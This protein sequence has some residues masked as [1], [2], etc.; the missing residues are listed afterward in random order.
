MASIFRE[1]AAEARRQRLY[2]DI[3]IYD[4]R[5]SSVFVWVVGLLA[6]TTVAVAMTATYPR[7]EQ[8]RGVVATSGPS[9]KILPLRSGTVERLYVKNGDWVERG[10]PLALVGVDTR[11]AS[12][13]GAARESLAALD[14]RYASVVK[15]LR[16]SDEVLRAERSR[17]NDALVANKS[18][19]AAL[20]Q[21]LQLQ[22]AII[23]AKSDEL[24][25]IEPVADQGYV[26]KFELDHRRQALLAERQRL[27]QYQQQRVQLEASR[28]SLT[29]QLHQ[30]PTEHER[31]SAELEAQLNSIAQEQSRTRV[32]IGY[33]LVAPIDGYV[34]AV[35]GTLGRNADPRIPLMVLVPKETHFRVELLA[36]SKAAGFLRTGQEVRIAY[37]AFPYKQFGTASGRIASISRTTYA[38]TELDL[39]L[40]VTEPVYRVGVSLDGKSSPSKAELLPLQAG[41][42]LTASVVL[43]RRSFIDWL[44]QPLN[45]VRNRA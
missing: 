12:R 42:T 32:E 2:G 24:A 43:E 45:A 19:Y 8:V 39:P 31:R 28:L 22:S 29:A 25:R 38:P 3:V 14:A 15:Q 17:F 7:T 34:T 11:D 44:L 41:M 1:Q 13:R 30:L 33:S 40:Q 36:P 10:T 26:S 6:M 27:A 21:Q 20:R 4:N 5:L 37:D 16:N 35:Q 23:D 9:A 18:E